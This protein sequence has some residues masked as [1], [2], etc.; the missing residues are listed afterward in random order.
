[1]EESDEEHSGTCKCIIEEKVRGEGLVGPVNK[2]QGAP[3][4]TRGTCSV[5]E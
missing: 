3:L 5:L 1:M 2:Y 4:S